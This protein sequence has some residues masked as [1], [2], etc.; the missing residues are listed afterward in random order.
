MSKRVLCFSLGHLGSL[1]AGLGE[2]SRQ[3]G[4]RL[5][6]RAT[7]LRALGVELCFHVQ[8]ELQGAFGNDVSYV[9]YRPSQRVL[10]WRL[11]NCALWHSAFQH[12][13]ARPPVG[14]G[15]RLLTVHDLNFRYVGGAGSW[16]DGA[17]TRL[18]I[19]R[20]DCLVA[21]SRYV[22]DD[23][24]RHIGWNGPIS[25]IYNGAS[26]LTLLPQEPVQ[27][28]AS[29]PF[30]FHVSR[31][32][33]SK[34]VGAI[35]ELARSWPER[36]FVLAG[37]A[38]GHSKQLHER[39]RGLPANVTVLL[40]ISDGAKAWLLQNCEAFLF[41]SLTEGFGLPPIEAMYFGTPV[42]LSDRTCL[43][44]IGADC[45]A[46]FSDFSAPAMRQVIERELPRLRSRRNDIRRRAELFDWDR[47]ADGYL[48]L[49]GSLL[50]IDVGAMLDGA[51]LGADAGASAT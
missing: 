43:P 10:A 13:I 42:F 23:V 15:R 32:A 49:Y 17:L 29:Q 38:W 34:N 48:S 28:L 3:L 9:P 16:R 7:A 47:C 11:E 12:N 35:I 44:E 30:F 22:A 18:S 50:G 20:S 31:M 39:P 45:A 5:A 21:I 1:D 26:D 4:E 40:G 46:Y 8:P 14:A 19:A 6:R 27:A 51:R 25:T 37:P 2:F 33:P 41:P 24:V 36:R